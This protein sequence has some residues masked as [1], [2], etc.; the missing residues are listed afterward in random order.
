MKSCEPWFR[1]CGLQQKKKPARYRYL[2]TA[3]IHILRPPVA[4]PKRRDPSCH[5]EGETRR[6]STP[7]KFFPARSD[8]TTELETLPILTPDRP[9]IRVPTQRFFVRQM[10]NRQDPRQSQARSR[11]WSRRNSM[12]SSGAPSPHHPQHRS[13]ERRQQHPP[14]QLEQSYQ[15]QNY[16][17]TYGP[18]PQQYNQPPMGG[19]PSGPYPNYGDTPAEPSSAG[20]QMNN[21]MMYNPPQDNMTQNNPQ[22]PP[23]PRFQQPQWNYRDQEPGYNTGCNESIYCVDNIFIYITFVFT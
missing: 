3:Q 16:N 20:Y 21:S 14:R 12:T 19:P 11:D 15:T 17:Q 13:E 5:G 2:P 4:E 18:P 10:S 1:T 6:A 7:T 9:F 23:E 8:H 22:W